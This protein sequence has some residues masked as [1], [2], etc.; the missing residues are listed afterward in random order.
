MQPQLSLMPT[1]GRAEPARAERRRGQRRALAVVYAWF[2]MILG[3]ILRLVA[4]NR[5]ISAVLGT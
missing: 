3:F 1:S 4:H 2:Y 5:C